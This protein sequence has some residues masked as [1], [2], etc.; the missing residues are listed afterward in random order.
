ME[1]DKSTGQLW[2]KQDIWMRT[3]I[4]NTEL[5]VTVSKADAIARMS[6]NLNFVKLA[7]TKEFCENHLC[8]YDSIMFRMV[9]SFNGTFK[10]EEIGDVAPK[11][12]SRVCKKYRVNYKL[13][14]GK[15]LN[16]Y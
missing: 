10:K 7:E 11:L 2:F 6:I 9:E 1:I 5:V 8:F 13:L 14:N 4:N 16:Y 15:R 12:Y 3:P